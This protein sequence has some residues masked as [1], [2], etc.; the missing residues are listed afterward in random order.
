MKVVCPGDDWFS[1]KGFC[2]KS[3]ESNVT[4]SY[5]QALQKCL[6]MG[7]DL[8]QPM[9]EIESTTLSL[10]LANFTTFNSTSYWILIESIILSFKMIAKKFI[11]SLAWMHGGL[12][13]SWGVHYFRVLLHFYDQIFQSLL[14]GYMRCPTSPLFPLCASTKPHNVITDTVIIWVLGSNLPSP[15]PLLIK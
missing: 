4:V 2:M 12:K 7:A 5:E 15:K 9:N 10:L 1:S 8:A 13:K 11:R 14:R 3:F 6:D